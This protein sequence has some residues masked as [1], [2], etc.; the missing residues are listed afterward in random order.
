M[1]WHPMWRRRMIGWAGLLALLT[2]CRAGE[3]PTGTVQV[4]ARAIHRDDGSEFRILVWSPAGAATG[5]R[6]RMKDAVLGDSGA[7]SDSLRRAFEER[8]T[9]AF[10]GRVAGTIP[11]I[12]ERPIGARGARRPDGSLL[13]LVVLVGA[14]NGEAYDHATLAARLAAAGAIA[15]TLPSGA[16]AGRAALDIDRDGVLAQLE[17]LREVLREARRWPSVDPARVGMAAWSTGGLAAAIAANEG[18]H[19]QALVSLDGATG[20]QYGDSLLA[21]IVP[22][23]WRWRI[24]YLDVIAGVSGAVARSERFL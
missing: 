12:L 16:A 14:V 1:T 11:E 7:S 8:F 9:Q 3:I 20:Y 18:E 5:E 23:D 6:L 19:A 2:T 15:V 4:E 24:P 17:D 13:P 10:G 22:A 21:G